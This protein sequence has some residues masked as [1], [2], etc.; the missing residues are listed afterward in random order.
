MLDFYLIYLYTVKQTNINIK[1]LFNV[2]KFLG[3]F[4]PI[5]SVIIPVYNDGKYIQ[6][7][8][9]SVISQTFSDWEAIC[10]N[11]G[12]TDDSLKILKQYVKKDSRIKIINQKNQGVIVSRTNAIKKAHS[13]YIFMLDGDDKIA[14][15]TLEKTYKAIISG[16]GDVITFRVMQFGRKNGEK[17]LPKPNKINMADRNCLVNAALMKKEDFFTCGGFDERFS[18][19]LEDYDLWLNLL[20][21]QNKKFYRIPEIL[22]FYRIKPKKLSRNYQRRNT[23]LKD[24]IKLLRIKY[25]IR[26]WHRISN[27]LHYPKRI[28]HFFFR[29]QDGYIKIFRIPIKRIAKRN[30]VFNE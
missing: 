5:I 18:S 23:D 25:P 26:K 24:I 16:K 12:S 9:D 30:I 3:D 1:W 15:T 28:T 10:V 19:M 14:P 27:I 22:F 2:Y 17:I 21:K 4:M 20:Y 11:D 8:L 6:E 29:I 13:E 7:T